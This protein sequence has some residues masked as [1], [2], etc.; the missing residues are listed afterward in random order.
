VE[1]VLEAAYTSAARG[2][3][4]LTMPFAG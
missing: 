2:G 3:E 4:R 1:E